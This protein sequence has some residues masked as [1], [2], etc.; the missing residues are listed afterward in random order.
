MNEQK[1]AVLFQQAEQVVQ[2]VLQKMPE[3]LRVEAE[4]V[5]C[6]LEKWP[7][8]GED[9]LGRCLSFEENVVSEGVCD[10]KVT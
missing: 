1:W 8:D 6:L 10:A 4:R 2:D 3:E 9:V 7:P 5:P